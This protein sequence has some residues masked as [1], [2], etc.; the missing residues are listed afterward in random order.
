LIGGSHGKRIRRAQADSS[1]ASSVK[2]TPGEVSQPQ[3]ER[4]R[5]ECDHPRSSALKRREDRDQGEPEGKR[6]EK[7]A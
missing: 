5:G 1:G 2:R 7:D 6:R 4:G 3:R